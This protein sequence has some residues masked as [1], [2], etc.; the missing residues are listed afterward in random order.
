MSGA[1]T[2]RHRVVQRRI[3]GAET[4]L[5]SFQNITNIFR[6]QKHNLVTFEGWESA[7][8]EL[9]IPH[10]YVYILFYIPQP[11]Y[12]DDDTDWLQTNN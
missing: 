5:P 11:S 12:D 9:G 1:E 6:D 3:G 7:C 2:A 10:M 4:T 8:R